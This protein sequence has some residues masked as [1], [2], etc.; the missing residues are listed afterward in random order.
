MQRPLPVVSDLPLR[1]QD[2]TDCRRCEVHCD[3]VVYPAACVEGACPFLYAYSE[4]GRTYVG[5][6]QKIYD[7]EIDLELLREAQGGK[8][9]FGAVKARRQP[10]PMCKAEV[11]KCYEN[12]AGDMGCVN[13][14]FL[15][16]PQGRPSFRVISQ[17]PLD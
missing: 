9:G 1:P 7:V 4:H 2:E 8:V 3:K 5:C 6:M 11:S 12:R 13:P 17:V 10:L 14:E 15:E 16:L